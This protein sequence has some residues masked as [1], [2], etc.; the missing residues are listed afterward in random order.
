MQLNIKAGR[1]EGK[2]TLLVEYILN[3][4]D[5]KKDQEVLLCS[6]NA[7]SLMYL[8]DLLITHAFKRKDYIKEPI[9]DKERSI[10]LNGNF[11][12]KVALYGD[13][14]FKGYNPDIIAVDNFDY[15]HE[16]QL[17]ALLPFYKPGKT[18][19]I[20]TETES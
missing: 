20:T 1:R 15:V 13:I 18:L 2:T 6:N 3:A 5:G 9:E 4:L 16:L 14:K 19:L 11:I 17:A 8:S 10:T 7:S 12:R